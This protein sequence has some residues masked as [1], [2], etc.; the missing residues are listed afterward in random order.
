MDGADDL[1]AV[2]AVQ[3]DAGDPKVGVPK[4]TLDDDQRN[5]FVRHLDRVSMPQPMRGEPPSHTRSGGGMVQLLAC[6]R[7]LPPATSRR[8]VNHTQHRADWELATDLKPRIELLPCP[9]IHSDLAALA[10]L[11]APDKYGPAGSVEVAFQQRERFTD[12]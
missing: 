10:A 4:L 5:A 2:D 3:V 6:R 8:S 1:A 12:S 9:S 11:A 7:R